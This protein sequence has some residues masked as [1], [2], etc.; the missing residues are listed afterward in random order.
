[1]ETKSKNVLSDKD[2]CTEYDGRVEEMVNGQ[3]VE[4]LYGMLCN[5]RFENYMF[6]IT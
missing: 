4:E 5:H 3:L 6:Y 1:M 2:L